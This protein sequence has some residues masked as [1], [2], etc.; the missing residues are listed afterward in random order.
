M[1]DLHMHSRMSDDGEFSPAELVEKCRDAEIRFLSI[2][3][4]NTLAALPEAR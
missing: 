3:D 1:L 4:H 2:T